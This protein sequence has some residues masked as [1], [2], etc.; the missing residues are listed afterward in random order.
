MNNHS[1]S[2]YDRATC[3][4]TPTQHP[5]YFVPD[6]WSEL[7][8]EE[9]SSGEKPLTWYS[10]YSSCSEFCEEWCA[11]RGYSMVDFRYYAC[12]DSTTGYVE[13]GYFSFTRYCEAD[14]PTNY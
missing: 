13:E 7:Y 9:K 10:N 5:E 8:C 3:Y 12:G 1:H 14:Y 11:S 2:N 4:D 6:E